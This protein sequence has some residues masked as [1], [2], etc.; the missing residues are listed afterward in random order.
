MPKFVGAATQVLG[1]GYMIV[2]GEH[3]GRASVGELLEKGRVPTDGALGHSK[4][5]TALLDPREDAPANPTGCPEPLSAEVPVCSGQNETRYVALMMRR[6][7]LNSSVMGSPLMSR[8]T[9]S[10][11]T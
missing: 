11:T 3:P 2:L 8:R 10:Y 6:R 5:G 1:Q 7:S 4:V 9:S